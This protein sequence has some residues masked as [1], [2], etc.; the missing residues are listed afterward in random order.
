MRHLSLASIVIAGAGLL[1]P[2]DQAGAASNKDPQHVT[3]DIVKIEGDQFHVRD[4]TGAERQIHVG[5]DTEQY[6]RFMPGDRIDAWVFPNGHAKTVMI[7]RSAAVMDA[8]PAGQQ[9]A[10]E[11]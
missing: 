6:G 3:V 4:E 5:G 2:I 10:K 1:V 7:V 11:K 9:S 8:D